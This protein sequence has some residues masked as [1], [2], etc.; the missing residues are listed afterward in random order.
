MGQKAGDD[1]P[2]QLSSSTAGIPPQK[3]PG[4][5]PPEFRDRVPIKDQIGA[6][7][8][9]LYTEVVNEP[10]PERLLELMRKLDDQD[11]ET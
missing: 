1:R 4:H 5:D 3:S 11:R 7:L 10:I 9:A 8:Q 6:K 2:M